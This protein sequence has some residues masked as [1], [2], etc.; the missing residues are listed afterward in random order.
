MVPSDAL[1]YQTTDTSNTTG[2]ITIVHEVGGSGIRTSGVE[3]AAVQLKLQRERAV[4]GSFH[5]DTELLGDDG[6][7]EDVRLVLV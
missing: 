7:N 1:R 4:D 2:C 3:R 6:G 5:V